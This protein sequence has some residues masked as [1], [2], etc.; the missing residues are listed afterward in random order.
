MPSVEQV[1]DLVLALRL[2]AEELLRRMG[3]KL[4]PPAAAKLPRE[5]VLG[6]LEMDAEEIR[7]VTLLVA[8]AGSAPRR[9]G[10][11]P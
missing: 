6:L 5:L 3:F 9:S 2:S 1:N 11:A 8:R 7:G 10:T 4:T